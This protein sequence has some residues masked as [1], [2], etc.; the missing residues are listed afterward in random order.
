MTGSYDPQLRLYQSLATGVAATRYLYDGAQII[1]EYNSANVLS[2]ALGL[3]SEI[4]R[5]VPLS[6]SAREFQDIVVWLPENADHPPDA[7]H[8]WR[9]AHPI[10]CALRLAR[11]P[12]RGREIV[13]GWGIVPGG[14]A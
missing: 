7:D 13:D 2:A 9:V 14:G 12:A 10:V 5:V 4:G 11:D 1:G 6:R 8:P 3:P